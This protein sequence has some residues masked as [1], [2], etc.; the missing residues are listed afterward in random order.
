MYLTKTQ[1]NIPQ[2]TQRTDKV[3]SEIHLYLVS[4]STFCGNKINRGHETWS[5][6]LW[7]YT[8]V[9]VIKIFVINSNK[10]TNH[11]QQFFQ[12]ITW[13]LFTVQHVLSVL[14]PI[15]RSSTTTVA[16]SGFTVGVWWWQC[17][18]SWSGRLRRP[19]HDHQHCYHHAPK[20]KPEAATVV[21]ELLMMG[22]RTSETWWT[23]N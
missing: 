19:E 13:R 9:K 17:C 18:W 14:T 1:E 10:L 3:N 16:A 2:N 23:V 20:I 8:I 15:I 12:F 4:L 6:F 21:V 22:V 7:F 11:T 5:I